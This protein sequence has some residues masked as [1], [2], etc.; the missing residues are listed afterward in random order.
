MKYLLDANVLIALCIQEHAHH[1]AAMRWL[2]GL[3]NPQGRP[4]TLAL[5]PITEG[6]LVRLVLRDQP[7]DG[8][9][10]ALALLKA[11]R[12]W[13]GCEFWPDAPSYLDVEW[14]GVMGHK[15]VTDAYLATLAASRGA[16]LASFD[17]GLAALRPEAVVPVPVE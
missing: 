17:R 13:P 1:G 16:R 8:V 3:G 15:Q 4:P 2:A 11:L 5:C 6:A 12:S 14:R 7:N 10:T 9:G